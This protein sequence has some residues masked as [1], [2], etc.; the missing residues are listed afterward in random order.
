ML[1]EKQT[2]AV[3]A[4]QQSGHNEREAARTIGIDVKSL[5][6]RLWSAARAGWSVEPDRFVEAAPVGFGLTKSTIQT[7]RDGEVVQRWDRVSPILSEITQ[8]YFN[9]RIPAASLVT[10]IPLTRNDE[11]MLEWC[12]FDTHQG[13]LS[14]AQETGADYDSEIARTLIVNAAEKIFEQVG[15]VAETVIIGGGDNLHADNRSNQTE[16]SHHILDTDSRYQRV[17]RIAYET[18]C[19]AI[20]VALHR[21]TLVRIIILSGNHDYHASIHLAM[22]LQAH[23]R[24]ENRVVIDTSPAKHKHYRWGTNYFMASHGDTGSKRLASYLMNHLIKNNITGVE[25][26]Y[27]RAGHLH[28]RGRTT[29]AGLTEEDGVI[30]ELFPTLAAPDAFTHENAY[31]GV[32]A[33]IASLWHKQWGQRSRIELGI[34]ELMSEKM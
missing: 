9:Q 18:W 12:L 29:P 21:S 20:D 14:W 32:R 25:R 22:I 34:K 19:T 15:T 2:A 11:L 4:Y 3:Q 33:T 6:G 16:K 30:V 26:M 17:V 31:C 24:N 27:V 13:L 28:K 7:D 23:Y 1:T 8:E 5:R 10:G